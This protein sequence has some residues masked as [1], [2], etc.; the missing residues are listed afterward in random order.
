MHKSNK[1]GKVYIDSENYSNRTFSGF[2]IG[3]GGNLSCRIYNKTL[4]IKNQ[5]RNGLK[6][7]G[8]K[9]AGMAQQLYGEQNSK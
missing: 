4:E 7:Y 6:I 3:K 9:T 8:S 5:I 2:V 1:I